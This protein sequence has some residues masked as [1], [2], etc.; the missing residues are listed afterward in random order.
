MAHEHSHGTHRGKSNIGL[1]FFLNL[2]FTFV[3]LAGGVLT[4]SVAILSDAVHDLGDSLSLALAW[5]F[6][7]LSKRAPTA[8]YTY[9]Y[10]RFSLLGAIINSV[11]LTVGSIYIIWEA[12]PRL[13]APEETSAKGMFLLAV[14]GIIV[15]GLAVLRT[16]KSASIN[17][18]VVSL[19][20]LEDVLGWA[21]VLVGAVVMHLT[22]WTVIDPILSLAVACFVLVNVY[23][24]IRRVLPI[25]LE[26]TPA[27]IS[28][29]H[30]ANIL[31]STKGVSGIHDLHIWSLDESYNILT[32]H[33]VLSEPHS[34]EQ[35][36]EMKRE[37]RHT[38]LR[39]GIRHAT[40]EFEL[41]SEECGFSEMPQE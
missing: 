34:P 36:A 39:E 38:L 40:L 23:R 29:S 9:G 13:F 18:R 26:G 3:E 5:Y 35:L 4:N 24:N 1:A 14:L 11:V 17:E 15:N 28:K 22:G 20:M 30:I 32:T 31:K 7:R 10:K 16:R 21:A 12:I 33:I 41:D 25:V 6:Q 2:A 37:I 19:H 8:H 27:G